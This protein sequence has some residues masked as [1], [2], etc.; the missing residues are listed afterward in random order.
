MSLRTK[1]S[2]C[3]VFGSIETVF[4]PLGEPVN[5]KTANWPSDSTPLDVVSVCVVPDNA[6]DV[7]P[8][9]ARSTMSRFRF[10]V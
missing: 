1:Y 8:F 6:I 4:V 3:A 5:T 2:F 7:D 10:V 9:S